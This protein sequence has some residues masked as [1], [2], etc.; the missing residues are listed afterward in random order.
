MRGTA[1][2]A[3]VAL[4]L[5]PSP[6][7][8]D[9]PIRSVRVSLEAKPDAQVRV[10]IEN[11]RDSPLVESAIGLFAPGEASPRLFHYSNFLTDP[12]GLKRDGV[13]AVPIA[14]RGRRVI[15]FHT[16]RSQGQ[17]TPA[18]TLVTFADGYYE[19][20][21]E[22]LT[23]WRGLR[24]KHADELAYWIR[25]MDTT[26]RDSVDAV[27]RHFADASAAREAR[28]P[29]EGTELRIRM[30]N[31]RRYDGTL[32]SM[33]AAVGR[34][35]DAAARQW[36]TLQSSLVGPLAARPIR[37]AT[38]SPDYSTPVE[39]VVAIENTG[40]V[41]VEAWGLEY[42]DPRTGRSN[43]PAEMH[44]TCG[45]RVDVSRGGIAPGEVLEVS[46]RRT[47]GDG[48]PSLALRFVLFEDLSFEGSMSARDEVFRR[49]E[50]QADGLAYVLE[51]LRRADAEP[52]Q[53]VAI[54]AAARSERARQPKEQT[55]Y[56]TAVWQLDE[57]IREAKASPSNFAASAA[58]RED[59]L[60]WQRQRLLRHLTR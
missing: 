31:F 20:T 8:Q 45:V 32:R 26:P 42:I 44:D 52:S 47:L 18:L 36:T 19:G 23:E 34:E 33:L 30:E 25:V 7:P 15:A 37:S 39:Y 55:R 3:C 38:L 5:Q 2:I 10:V 49:R 1:V 46:S 53:T 58:S 48:P 13:V 9:T 24:Q 4:F 12:E 35:R 29:G 16:P 41:P 43:G 54:L 14:F 11:L 6:T 57:L 27:Q 17:L 51:A 56:D 40:K 21:L 50:G 22:M 59:A 60:E 28:N